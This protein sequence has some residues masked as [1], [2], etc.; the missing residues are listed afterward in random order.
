MRSPVV[1]ERLAHL[2]ELS[3]ESTSESYITASLFLPGLTCPANG[4]CSPFITAS[5]RSNMVGC[6]NLVHLAAEAVPRPCPKTS[7]PNIIFVQKY[8]KN[9]SGSCAASFPA[10]WSPTIPSFNWLCS[11]EWPND[12]RQFWILNTTD[13]SYRLCVHCMNVLL[14]LSSDTWMS[15]WCGV[16]WAANWFTTSHFQV[17]WKHGSCKTKDLFL[18]ILYVALWPQHPFL[19][20]CKNQYLHKGCTQVEVLRS[21][22]HDLRLAFPRFCT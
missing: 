6:R 13:S 8:L 9:C 4:V 21:I 1:R 16:P 12:M 22:A 18:K 10:L 2:S 14:Q 11:P 5:F 7:S 19:F 15:I 3:L 17:G 20:S